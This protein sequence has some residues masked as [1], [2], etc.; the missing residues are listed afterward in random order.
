MAYN[1]PYRSTTLYPPKTA[2][3]MAFA[4]QNL[5]P[6]APFPWQDS[7]DRSTVGFDPNFQSYTEPAREEEWYSPIDP[8]FQPY[9]GPPREER[10]Y[11][12]G[13][14]LPSSRPPAGLRSSMPTL[15]PGGGFPERRYTSD[16]A[17]GYA[18]RYGTNLRF[19]QFYGG[20]SVLRNYPD[21]NQWPA[22][23]VGYAPGYAG[24]YGTN[25]RQPRFAPPGHRQRDLPY[26]LGLRP[27]PY[28]PDRPAE[29][30]GAAPGYLDFLDRRRRDLPYGLRSRPP[31]PRYRS[32][33]IG[34][35]AQRMYDL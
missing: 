12:P 3:G 26:G 8:N 28:A 23:P 25:F 5:A 18:G 20:P 32:P 10:R 14:H 9:T 7:T 11:P 4:Q 33:E 1:D 30:G 34:Y 24:G 16:Y 2:P 27:P 29:Y 17:P 31:I 22:R 21:R 19:P 15:Y 6:R 13:A 35:P